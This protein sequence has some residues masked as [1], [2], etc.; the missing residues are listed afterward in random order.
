MDSIVFTVLSCCRYI[1]YC[2]VFQALEWICKIITIT[3]NCIK[4]VQDKG[5]SIKISALLWKVPLIRHSLM[6]TY[7]IT[8]D[9]YSTIITRHL[10]WQLSLSTVIANCLCTRN[11][12]LT[13]VSHYQFFSYHTFIFNLLTVSICTGYSK[14][15][16]NVNCHRIRIVLLFNL[17]VCYWSL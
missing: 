14:T 9:S 16:C 4:M 8:P 5:N 3:V 17:L 1:D 15:T 12:Y 13:N 6:S 2:A 10:L 11:S 7:R